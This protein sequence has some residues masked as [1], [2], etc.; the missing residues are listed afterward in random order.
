MKVEDVQDYRIGENEYCISIPFILS[1]KM[2]IG[3]NM[4]E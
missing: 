1:V 4:Y 2:I 3:Y